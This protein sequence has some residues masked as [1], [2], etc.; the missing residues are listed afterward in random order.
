MII[1]Y[2]FKLYT[3]SFKNTK[4]L[5]MGFFMSY[6]CMCLEIINKTL[7]E[8]IPNFNFF[9]LVLNNC[10]VNGGAFVLYHMRAAA[11]DV[12]CGVFF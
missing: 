8:F 7:R 4:Q 3:F 9:L 5:N 10:N 2:Y 11:D 1:V 12:C 6:V